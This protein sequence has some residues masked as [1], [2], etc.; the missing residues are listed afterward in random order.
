MV[1]LNLC[2]QTALAAFQKDGKGHNWRQIDEN[3]IDCCIVSS[4]VAYYT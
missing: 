1:L 2:G 4:L 3:Y